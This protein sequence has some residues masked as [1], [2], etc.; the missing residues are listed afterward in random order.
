M[1]VGGRERVPGQQASDKSVEGRQLGVLARV[2]A[3]SRKQTGLNQLDEGVQ[4]KRM[5]LHRG[6]GQEEQPW[7]ELLEFVSE[8]IRL[9]RLR[10]ASLEPPAYSMGFVKDD[11]IPICLDN[12]IDAALVR[13]ER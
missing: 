10:L 6:C 5:K 1:D 4:L 2:H 8:A 3:E 11:K 13:R 7:N 9:S 12:G